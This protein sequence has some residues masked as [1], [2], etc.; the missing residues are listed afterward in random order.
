[1]LAIATVISVTVLGRFRIFGAVPDLALVC[2][3]FF[4]F[5][6]GAAAGLEA[7]VAAGVMADI[8]SLDYLGINT[9]VYAAAGFAAGALGS[10]FSGGS[11][12]TAA[13]AVFIATVVSMC[14]RYAVA[15]SISGGVNFGFGEYAFTCVLGAGLY[16][17]LVSVPVFAKFSGAFRL[18]DEDDLL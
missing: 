5:Y 7:G 14:L 2:V 12:R 17:A 18:Q 4:G 1:M 3:S 6:L 10:G 8:Y 9:L 11:K 16:T 13:L 15:S